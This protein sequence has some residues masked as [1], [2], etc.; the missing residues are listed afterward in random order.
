MKR[1]V[2]VIVSNYVGFLRAVVD[3]K[4]QAEFNVLSS[5]RDGLDKVTADKAFR[6]L[7]ADSRLLAELGEVTY[8]TT[9][10]AWT[11]FDS[12]YWIDYLRAVFIKAPE[13]LQEPVKVQLA[14]I[15]K[16]G[17]SMKTDQWSRFSLDTDPRF[18]V[19]YA[20]CQALKAI[21]SMRRSGKTWGVSEQK[22]DFKATAP[23]DLLEQL[24]KNQI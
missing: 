2:S 18:S 6:V 3:E 4:G 14:L 17:K 10:L 8:W 19:L 21:S 13:A 7:V 15:L 11:K 16:A 12:Q 1:K 24:R 9:S 20:Y 23:D 5:W 22:V